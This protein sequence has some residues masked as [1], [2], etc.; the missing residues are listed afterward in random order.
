MDGRRG[1]EPLVAPATKTEA[2]E[3]TAEV[4]ERVQQGGQ[5]AGQGVSLGGARGEADPPGRAEL[6]QGCPL[7]RLPREAGRLRVAGRVVEVTAGL[8]YQ[9]AS[10][11][12]RQPAG[13][14][15]EVALDGVGCA[16]PHGR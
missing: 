16:A 10:P 6:A 14:A 4:P 8:G 5:E 1:R 2:A 3:A 12:A 13:Q 9:V 15:A 11:G 7:R